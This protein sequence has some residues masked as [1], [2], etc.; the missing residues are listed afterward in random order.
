[1]WSW[2]LWRIYLPQEGKLL[3]DCKSA[4]EAPGSQPI[5]PLKLRLKLDSKP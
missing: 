4:K 2:G 3:I 5:G 1:M